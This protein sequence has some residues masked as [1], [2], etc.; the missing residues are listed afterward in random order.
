TIRLTL[1]TLVLGI[2]LVTIAPLAMIDYVSHTRSLE[3]L[4]A[5]YFGVASETVDSRLQAMLQP[6]LPILDEAVYSATTQGRLDPDD[7]VAVLDYG[8]ARVRFV[9]GLVWFYYGDAATGRFVGVRKEADGSLVL[10]RSSPEVEGGARR[11]ETVAPD[12]S[13]SPR[14]SAV[15]AGF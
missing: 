7:E 11:E 4:E 5:R 8:L 6:A 9:D 2:L 15:P 1:V 3:H 14:P 13:R 10:A 12:G